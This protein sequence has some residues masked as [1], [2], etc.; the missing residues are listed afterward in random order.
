MRIVEIGSC[1]PNICYNVEMI[2][3]MEAYKLCAYCYILIMIATLAI[4][5]NDV[6]KRKRK[7]WTCGTFIGIMLKV[8]KHD[9]V[10]IIVA[11]TLLKPCMSWTLNWD[12]ELSLRMK[13]CE[14]KSWKC[15]WGKYVGKSG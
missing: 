3:M 12:L 5:W 4:G 11:L 2:K 10:Q 9:V 15:L 1:C 7:S 8:E 13:Y 6:E 14:M